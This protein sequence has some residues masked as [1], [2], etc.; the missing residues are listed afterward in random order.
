MEKHSERLNQNESNLV[1][2]DTM[3]TKVYSVEGGR[4]RGRG[5]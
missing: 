4:G 1:L 3:A 5:W 2:G